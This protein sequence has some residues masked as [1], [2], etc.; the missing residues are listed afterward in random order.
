MF[1]GI[2]ET[3]PGVKPD[4]EQALKVLE[5]SAEVYGAWQGWDL[6]RRAG[7]DAETCGVRRDA[8]VS[9][10]ADVIQAVCNLLDALGVESAVGAMAECRTRNEER[11]RM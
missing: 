4:K 7:F 10:C 11:G 9:E 3:F 8:L 6:V 1:V 5:E 2:V